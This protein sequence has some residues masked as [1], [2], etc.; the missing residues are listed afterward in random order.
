MFAQPYAQV[1]GALLAKGN[2]GRSVQ[3]SSGHSLVYLGASRKSEPWENLF[4]ARKGENPHPTSASLMALLDDMATG[5]SLQSIMDRFLNHPNTPKDWR[6]YMVK[7][8][9]MRRGES[10]CYVISPNPGYSLCML[11]GD[12]CDDRSYHYD[13]YLLALVELAQIEPSKIGN[14]GWPRCFP[15]YETNARY[16]VL[17]KSSLKVRCV[18]NGWLWDTTELDVAQV[19]AFAQI[20]ARFDTQGNQGSPHEWLTMA[21]QQNGI[22]TEDRIVKG[23][24]L[25]K[26]LI[27]GGI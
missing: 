7:Y 21:A 9:A 22:D 20:A 23:A 1:T 4:R 26:A 15:G 27:D 6:Y 19:S 3:R 24:T 11:R 14:S 10:G 2:D 18:V 16:L 13:P 17:R 8:E 12:S 25:L 5:L